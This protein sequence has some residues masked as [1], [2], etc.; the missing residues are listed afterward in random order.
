MQDRDE[1]EWDEHNEDHIADHDV[2]PDEAE[3]AATDSNA[4][5]R[6]RGKDRFGNPRYLC[7]G[8]TESGRI[9]LLVVDLKPG[10]QWR[11]GSAR[12]AVPYERKEYR[13]RSK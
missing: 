3:E 4:I 9:L 5:F 13:R 11:V 7:L 1:F 8:K 6:R 2:D 10:R 12:E